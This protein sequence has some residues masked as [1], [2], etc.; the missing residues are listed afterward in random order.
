MQS[1]TSPKKKVAC[2]RCG[3]TILAENETG[4]LDPHDCIAKP[5]LRQGNTAS[6]NEAARIVHCTNC[7]KELDVSMFDP[8]EAVQ[9]CYCKTSFPLLK[10]FAGFTLLRSYQSGWHNAV[11]LAADDKTGQTT[12]LKVLSSHV[13]SQP[14]SLDAFIQERERIR[15][16]LSHQYFANFKSGVFCGFHFFAIPM[17]S[18]VGED[19][20]IFGA[21]V[22]QEVETKFPTKEDAFRR[23]VICSKCNAPINVSKLDVLDTAECSQC[24]HTF[25]LHRNLGPYRID[26][27]LNSGGSGLVY[28]A[29]S[30]DL[31]K[32]VALKILSSA[33]QQRGSETIDQ[34]VSECSLTRKLTHPNVIQAYDHGRV[35]GFYYISLELVEGLSLDEMLKVIESRIP[36]SKNPDQVAGKFTPYALAR[37]RA[38]EALPEIIALEIA[39]QA[40]CGLGFAHQNRLVHGDV[41]PSNIMVTYEG[42]VKVLDFGLVKFANASKVFEEAEEH[43]VYGTPIY[44]P[45]ERVRGEPEDNRS[46]IYGL[47]ATL[48]HLLRGVPPFTGESA[49]DIAMKQVTTPLVPFKAYVP[50]V[51]D[52]TCF[53]VEKS[54]KKNVEERYTSHADFIS[55]LRTAKNLLLDSLNMKTTDGRLL[56]KNFMRTMPHVAS[57][58]A[59][60]RAETSAIRTYK[61][62]T[63]AIHY[64]LG[65][66]VKRAIT[67]Q[68]RKNLNK[69]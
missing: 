6:G 14:G 9:C 35:D 26:Y 48:Y 53:I 50:W 8:L 2:P 23:E 69:A 7:Q 39:L 64:N 36:P 45:P 27:R 1:F 32:D 57:S 42:I 29:H 25:E 61:Y 13:L 21:A 37:D 63:R 38:K 33:E 30:H 5:D 18:D 47:G 60:K 46:D 17:D 44:I 20:S 54:L 52:A 22:T 59:W 43:P 55:D 68:I 3:K 62:V 28:L 49:V 40:A 31:H 15:S 56:L 11:Y 24:G 66:R 4:R 12:V 58:R 16:S 51:T 67:G 41:K 10:S 65:I 34:F 19:P